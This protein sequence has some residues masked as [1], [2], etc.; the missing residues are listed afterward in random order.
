MAADKG[1]WPGCFPSALGLGWKTTDP[2]PERQCGPRL[3]PWGGDQ[4]ASFIRFPQR[5]P[6]LPWP[7]GTR[8]TLRSVLRPGKAG[9]GETRPLS[10][11]ESH[12][13]AVAGS[14]AGGGPHTF[15]WSLNSCTSG[16]WGQRSEVLVGCQ[17]WPQPVLGLAWQ[18]TAHCRWAAW[19]PV[20]GGPAVGHSRERPV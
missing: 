11:S 6:S 16:C 10:L 13:G 4:A 2:A 5:P 18:L 20:R 1:G 12:A 8:P 7:W 14:R 3:L 9:S 17:E 19:V 15:P